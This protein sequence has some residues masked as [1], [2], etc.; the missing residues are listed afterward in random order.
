M[1]EIDPE[2]VEE[3]MDKAEELIKKEEEGKYTFEV[4]LST[5]GKHS[6]H[7]TATTP[8]GRREAMRVATENYD[9]IVTRYGTKQAQAVRE[10]SKENG[11]PEV[12]QETCSH[13]QV[14]FTQSKTE[15]N[16][17]RWFKSCAICGKFLSWQ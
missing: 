16:P 2:E 11:K 8:E 1:A 15:K 17:G 6:I 13:T 10:Y 12:N 14:K 7:C 9:Y 4:W 3:A 5:D